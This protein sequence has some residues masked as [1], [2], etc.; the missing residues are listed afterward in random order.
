MGQ[1]HYGE[2]GQSSPGS[3][4]DDR[5]KA[6]SYEEEK[7]RRRRERNRDGARNYRKRKQERMERL[8]IENIR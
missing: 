6:L 8:K 4:V 5:E 7:K 1:S 2:G 3:S